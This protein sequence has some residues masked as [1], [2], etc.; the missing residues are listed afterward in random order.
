[1][2]NIHF[3]KAVTAVAKETSIVIKAQIAEAKKVIRVERK[4]FVFVFSRKLSFFTTKY[5]EKSRK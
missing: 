3:Y 2:G 5:D 4:V 1:M